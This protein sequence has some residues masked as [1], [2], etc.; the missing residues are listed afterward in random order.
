V[1]RKLGQGDVSDVMGRGLKS[2]EKRLGENL[3]GGDGVVL[4]GRASDCAKMLQRGQ[5]RVRRGTFGLHL[6]WRPD[7][8]QLG[9]DHRL[10]LGEPL[11]DPID[12]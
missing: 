5:Q 12:R 11:P 10:F 3:K 4:A 7:R 9:S 2:E 6:R 8:R 1:R